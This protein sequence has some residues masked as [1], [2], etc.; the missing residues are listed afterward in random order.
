MFHYYTECRQKDTGAHPELR[1]RLC[2]K[3][4][5]DAAAR[6]TRHWQRARG[7]AP[8]F[9]AHLQALERRSLRRYARNWQVLPVDQ[10]DRCQ[11]TRPIAPRVT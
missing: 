11:L 6:L 2:G 1:G 10:E 8:E 3:A 7:R 5:G 4:G 9:E